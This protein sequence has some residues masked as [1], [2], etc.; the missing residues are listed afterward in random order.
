MTAIEEAIGLSQSVGERPWTLAWHD[1][2]AVIVPFEGT[3][4]E[5]VVEYTPS[6]R[7]QLRIER[8][9]T[10]YGGNEFRVGNDTRLAR[11]LRERE[12]DHRSLDDHAPQRPLAGG[13]TCR[14]E[15]I[16]GWHGCAPIEAPAADIR[17]RSL[18]RSR[19][20]AMLERHPLVESRCPDLSKADRASHPRAMVF[21]HGT[22]SCAAQGLKVSPPAFGDAGPIYRYE[23]DTF[24]PIEENAVELAD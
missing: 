4:A 7:D 16:R 13:L 23:H 6:L 15:R 11:L 21:V 12:R 18:M 20:V 17:E 1:R 3:K 14:H 22:A 24:R 19:L 10:R 2:T 8:L 5:I 9:N